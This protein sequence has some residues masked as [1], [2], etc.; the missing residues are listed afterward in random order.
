MK[1]DRGSTKKIKT[2]FLSLFLSWL[3][4]I[5]SK[6]RRMVRRLLYPNRGRRAQM[7]AHT[8]D[9][10]IAPLMG[11]EKIHQMESLTVGSLMTKVEWQA[12]QKISAEIPLETLE[13]TPTRKSIPG[14]DESE[15]LTVGNARASL[16]LTT[17]RPVT[18]EMPEPDSKVAVSSIQAVYPSD[19]MPPIMGTE[20]FPRR[21]S[22]TVG[23]LLETVQWKTLQSPSQ[24]STIEDKIN[25][26]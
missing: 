9:I 22:L 4:G 8:P 26:D 3:R 10:K 24:T 17:P 18:E 14:F 12:P 15:S 13:A 23:N 19:R 11:A 2:D 20:Q 1:S 25:W 5:G 6:L 21:R 16:Q 7:V